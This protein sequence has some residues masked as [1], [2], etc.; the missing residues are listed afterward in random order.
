VEFVTRVGNHDKVV[1]GALILG[2]SHVSTL[3]GE[4]LPAM[5]KGKD[6]ALKAIER[7]DLR[8][9]WRWFNDVDLQLFAGGDIKPMSFGLLEAQFEKELQDELITRFAIVVDGVVIGWCGLFDWDDALSLRLAIAIGEKSYWGRRYG[10]D[11]VTT[12]L[13]YAFRHRNAHKVWLEVLATNERA[14]RSYKSCGFVQ[15]GRIRD[16]AWLQ[17]GYADELI[18]G[19]LRHE[20]EE[21]HPEA[22]V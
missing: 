18:M 22:T 8:T 21:L 11:A 4:E 6:V 20:W 7:S 15:E 16:N 3:T 10:R 14:I 12:L 19:I 5:L 2:K 1:A 17:G 13:D 9:I